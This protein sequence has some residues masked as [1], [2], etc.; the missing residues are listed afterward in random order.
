MTQDLLNVLKN[1]ENWEYGVSPE[2]LWL[3]SPS[4]KAANLV[5][6]LYFNELAV[7]A[8]KLGGKVQIYW[9]DC[10]HQPIEINEWM[11]Q[12][13][14]EMTSTQLLLPTGIQIAQMRLSLPLVRTLFEFA[15]NPEMLAGFVR[16]TDE[17][18]ICMTESIAQIVAA[19][20]Q[21]L[22]E[23]ITR[24]RQ[25]YWHPQD[26]EDFNRTW[27]QVLEANNPQ[28]TIEYTYRAKV[29]P[30]STEWRQWTTRFRLVEDDF[31]TNYHVGY[32]IATEP[33]PAPM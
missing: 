10:T 9:G 11:Y 6:D 19:S 2:G 21:D 16:L 17:R 7:T 32:A 30:T 1:S 18:Q 14:R 20:G 26:L 13:A 33:I 15:E 4:R 25:Q 8:C 5:T 12:E 22:E 23:V 3:A 31:S 24:R 27:Q 28:S 29:T